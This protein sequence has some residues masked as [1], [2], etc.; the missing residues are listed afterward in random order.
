MKIYTKNDFSNIINPEELTRIMTY[1]ISHGKLLVASSTVEN[2]YRIFSEN[3]YRVSWKNI[4]DN[5]LIEF[6][7][8]LSEQE[9]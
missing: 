4:D 8:W 6:E 1:L 9:I 5:I 3:K 7:N 2:L